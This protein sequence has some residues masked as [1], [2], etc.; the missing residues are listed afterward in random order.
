[1][2]ILRD[3]LDRR[4]VKLAV[5]ALGTL[6]VEPLY[7]LVD[8]A[9]VGRIGTTELAGLA[10]AATVL[11]TVV[12]LCVFLAYGTTASV[13]RRVGAGDE[14]GALS[15]GVAGLWL[16]LGLG[17]ALGLLTAVAAQPL[18]AVFGASDA[19]TE[20]GVAYLRVAAAGV[21]P[22]L[23]VLAAT[24]VLRGLRD[25]RTP[26]VVAVVANLANIALNVVLVYGVG[27]GIAGSA[28][29][30]VVAQA[31]SA[32][33]LVAVV[34]RGSRRSGAS[35]RPRP[36]LVLAA[37]RAGTAL[38]VRTLTLRVA[39][40]L[41]TLVAATLGDAPLA[42]HQV[43][44][45]VVS[46]LA[47]ALDALAIAGQTLT[48]HALGAADL[49]RT[50]RTTARI[51]RWGVGSGVVATLV[52]LALAPVLPGWFSTDP[53]VADALVPALVVVALVQPVSGLVFVLDGILIG[54]GDGAYLAVA[55]LVVLAVYAP[56]VGA[57]WLAGGGLTWLWVA[58]GGFLVARAVTL[59]RRER[60]GAWMVTGA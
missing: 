56:L 60:S 3:D 53:A 27:L 17:S 59:V 33:V 18:V 10:I 55:G 52:L 51:V 46:T 8:T 57:V 40:L 6:A 35:L 58:Y 22:M 2:A 7:V 16:A 43:A 32:L 48:G 36:S 12:G 39:L 26:L 9:I 31:A 29:G 5:P 24:G 38:L 41:G 4:I 37:A 19:V 15:A 20:Q 54:A 30:T 49:E 45:T 23:V 1:M 13:A 50:R 14:A 28:L 42:A 47:F 34:A 21:P 44:V 25:L 11:Q